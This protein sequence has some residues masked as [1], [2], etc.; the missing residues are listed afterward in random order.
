MK[1]VIDQIEP[2][3]DL[4]VTPICDEKF[5]AQIVQHAKNIAK[6]CRNH[7]NMSFIYQ[8][9]MRHWFSTAVKLFY[10]NVLPKVMAN[11]KYVLQ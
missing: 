3:R 5:K 10:S 9:F 4:G 2:V 1:E 8:T 6:V 7:D 11:I